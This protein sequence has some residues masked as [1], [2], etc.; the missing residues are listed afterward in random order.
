[1]YA[2]AG[3]VDGPALK[4]ADHLVGRVGDSG[5]GWRG[6]GQRSGGDRNQQGTDNQPVGKRTEENHSITPTIIREQLEK[7]L[8]RSYLEAASWTAAYQVRKLMSLVNC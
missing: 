6:G 3:S 2:I 8:H 7:I 1:M 5:H 4:V